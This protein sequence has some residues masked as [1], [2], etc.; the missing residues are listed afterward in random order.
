[1]KRARLSACPCAPGSPGHPIVGRR[2][3]SV[4]AILDQAYRDCFVQSGV[5][6]PAETLKVPFDVCFVFDD[7]V[8]QGALVVHD[9]VFV[10]TQVENLERAEQGWW[11]GLELERYDPDPDPLLIGQLDEV[12]QLVAHDL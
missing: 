12:T 9:R 4:G 5:P 11:C 3:S 8:D 10:S 7:F 2:E 1:M 6:Q